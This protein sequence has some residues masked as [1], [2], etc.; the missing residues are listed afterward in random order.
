MVIPL[1]KKQTLEKNRRIRHFDNNDKY[2]LPV[3]DW[4]G[5]IKEDGTILNCR[6]PSSC[7]KQ[8][9]L[10]LKVIPGI[11]K[12]VI[13]I[14]NKRKFLKPMAN[15]SLKEFSQRVDYEMH[16]DLYENDRETLRKVRSAKL[17]IKREKRLNKKIE[18]ISNKYKEIG[19]KEDEVI[20][21][22]YPRFGDIVNSPPIISEKTRQ[23]LDKNK[24]G[25][26]KNPD[27]DN[28][29]LEVRRSYSNIREK[30]LKKIGD[31]CKIKN[32]SDLFNIGG[33][34]VGI[35]KFKPEI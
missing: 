26:F 27:L 12:Q 17:K 35:G 4:D 28:Y 11:H 8:K 18:R 16:R 1:R 2:N 32:K 6:Y 31:I 20:N 13:G 15:E 19:D 14:K 3:S 23:K 7:Q 21:T 34:W 30:R 9:I 5:I 25:K 22:K 24:E 29:I 10:P 33:N